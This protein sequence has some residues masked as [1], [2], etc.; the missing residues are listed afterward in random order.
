[1]FFSILH[2][3]CFRGYCRTGIQAIP[4]LAHKPDG[5]GRTEFTIDFRVP[6]GKAFAA[7]VYFVFHADKL[8]FP[9]RMDAAPAHIVKLPIFSK[10][11]VDDVVMP[12]RLTTV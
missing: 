6:A 11:V 10:T 12:E 8:G 2:C 9:V 7:E 4:A 1:L 5:T 3:P